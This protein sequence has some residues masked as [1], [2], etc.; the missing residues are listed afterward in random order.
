MAFALMR[1]GAKVP[2]ASRVE[3]AVSR[4]ARRRGLLGRQ[5]LDTNAA[6]VLVPCSAVHTA[7]MR[8]PIDVVFVNREGRAVHIV[9]RMQPWRIAIAPSAHAVI[10]LAAGSVE[11]HD[12]RV[13]DVVRLVGDGPELPEEEL[14]K[15]RECLELRAS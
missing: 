9:T 6:L 13:G 5:R 8:F 1:E 11:K 12:I 7:C 14:Q 2:V 3:I 10:E 15:V 4:R